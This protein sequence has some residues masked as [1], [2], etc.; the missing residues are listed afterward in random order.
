METGILEKILLRRYGQ[1]VIT[2]LRGLNARCWNPDD[3]D[4]ASAIYR[5][6]M[7]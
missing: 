2:M 1:P 7:G 3:F 5:Y 6:E 4:Y